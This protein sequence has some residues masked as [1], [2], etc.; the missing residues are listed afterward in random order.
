MARCDRSCRSENSRHNRRI[1]TAV[2]SLVAMSATPMDPLRP[3]AGT[4]N[5]A[6]WRRRDMSSSTR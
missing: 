4:R 5:G 1:A 6:L 2:H 3:S